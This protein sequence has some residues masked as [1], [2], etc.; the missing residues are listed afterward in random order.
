MNFW[1]YIGITRACFDADYLDKRLVNV[2]HHDTFP[3]DIYTYGRACVHENK[4]DNI[5]RKCRGIIVNRNTGEIVARPFEKFFNLNT[6]GEPETDPTTWGMTTLVCEAPFG[7]QVPN[8]RITKPTV[9]EK[10]DGF[11]CT[12]YFWEGKWYCASKGSFA[13]P[14]AKWAT[15]QIQS[16]DMRVFAPGWTPIFEGICKSLRIVVDYKD[17]EGLVLTAHINN[18][19]G[20]ETTPNV[21]KVLAKSVGVRTACQHDIS[22]QD[23][24]QRSYDGTVKND[25]GFVLTW[26]RAGQTPFRLKVKYA[27]YIRIHR[28]VTGT[29]PK[30]I[31]EAIQSGWTSELD[32]LLNESTPWFN[33]FVTKWKHVI[34][35]DYNDI[36][37][38]AEAAFSVYR[39][40]LQTQYLSNGLWPTRKDYAQL[41]TRPES[42]KVAAVLFAMLD[43]KDYKQVI[44]KM[45]KNSPLL[46]GGQPMVDEYQL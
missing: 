9:W 19:T 30:R 21:L 26:Y 34:E 24:H 41:F 17:F 46:K 23:A 6:F 27:D 37:R 35:E 44:W 25:E 2:Q 22:W 42:K 45:V 18:E 12:G 11:L 16:L 15:K 40:V 20:E 3:L 13:S 29:S 8:W 32:G 7:P 43:G 28:M 39:G 5:T 10:V 31:L 38:M 36:E 4:W 14:H 33:R 1:Q